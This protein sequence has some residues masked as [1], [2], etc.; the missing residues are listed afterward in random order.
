MKY[1]NILLMAGLLAACSG[2]TAGDTGKTGD[3][4]DDVVGDD[5][6]DTTTTDSGD[7]DDDTG[8]TG[9]DD[10]I[11]PSAMGFEYDGAVGAGGA[12]ESYNYNGYT[13]D[14]SLLLYVADDRLFDTQDDIWQCL[15][16]T[17][18][19]STP[20]A[21]VTFDPVITP[22]WAYAPVPIAPY[23]IDCYTR[24]D[25]ALYGA[26]ASG[27]TDGLAGIPFGFAFGPIPDAYSG[28]QFA[29][30]YTMQ[31]NF[32][33]SIHGQYLVFDLKTGGLGGSAVG[34]GIAIQWDP[35]TGDLQTDGGGNLRWA[36]VS[37]GVFEGIISSG[38][39]ISYFNIF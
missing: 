8:T 23:D 27:L 29:S 30:Q 35:A 5:D 14:P 19:N 4:D 34:L 1:W 7:D 36:D 37:G 12:L 20:G 6:D 26:D 24:L 2:D 32:N 21:S 16:V 33:E 13:Y 39:A 10:Y 15:I 38:L 25:P 11:I 3:D 17:P 18:F 28:I 31:P 22:F 9:G